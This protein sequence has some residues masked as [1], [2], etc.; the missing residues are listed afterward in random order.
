MSSKE[1]IKGNPGQ[2]CDGTLNNTG[3]SDSPPAILKHSK[4]HNLS[5]RDTGKNKFTQICTSKGAS[6]R[7]TVAHNKEL[8]LNSLLY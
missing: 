3:Y 8:N 7:N 5:V 6:L 1:K 4:L 2:S